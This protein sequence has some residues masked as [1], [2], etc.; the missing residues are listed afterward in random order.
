MGFYKIVDNGYILGVGK[1]KGGIEITEAEYSNILSIVKNV[2]TEIG[3]S[4]KLKED[5]T[6]EE[7]EADT[8]IDDAEAIDIIF[9]GAE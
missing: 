1:G 3:K 2:L 5:L 6:W 7:V 8:E 9:G 4:Y